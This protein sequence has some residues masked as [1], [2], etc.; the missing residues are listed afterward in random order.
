MAA[1]VTV[2]STPCVTH[3]PRKMPCVRQMSEPAFRLNDRNQTSL[4]PEEKE[5]AQKQGNT[6]VAFS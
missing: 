3:G 4:T 1:M 5:E 2:I 6:W